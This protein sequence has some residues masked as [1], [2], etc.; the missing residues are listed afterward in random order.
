MLVPTYQPANE[1]VL[2]KMSER[3]PFPPEDAPELL[4][5]YMLISLKFDPTNEVFGLFWIPKRFPE[6]SRNGHFGAV[7]QDSEIVC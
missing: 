4:V 6:S 1:C 7:R 5:Q 2:K 3:S